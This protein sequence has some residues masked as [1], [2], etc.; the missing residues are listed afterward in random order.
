[1][2]LL[3]LEIVCKS[4]L[5]KLLASQNSDKTPLDITLD[6]F[7]SKLDAISDTLHKDVQ[8][9]KY[10][11]HSDNNFSHQ[12]IQNTSTYSQVLDY[13]EDFSPIRKK[14]IDDWFNTGNSKVKSHPMLLIIALLPKVNEIELYEKLIPSSDSLLGHI[15]THIFG[16]NKHV[17]LS[18]YDTDREIFTGNVAGD[19]NYI[20]NFSTLKL[21][22]I[23]K[24]RNELGFS[25][26]PNSL[27]SKKLDEIM[28][29]LESTNN[30]KEN[31]VLV[32][33]EDCNGTG[34]VKK[35][36]GFF[37]AE[38]KCP[39]CNGYGDLIDVKDTS[40]NTSKENDIKSNYNKSNADSKHSKDD[41]EYPKW[42]KGVITAKGNSIHVNDIN[43]KMK[44]TKLLW[45]TFDEVFVKALQKKVTEGTWYRLWFLP[46]Y[47]E[48]YTL[49]DFYKQYEEGQM[50]YEKIPPVTDI[51]SLL[52]LSYLFSNEE[53]ILFIP[54]N[55]PTL[56]FIDF[57]RYIGM[58]EINDGYTEDHLKRIEELKKFYP[59][60]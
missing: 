33:C 47:F 30:S 29:F 9:E 16:D 17:L 59:N 58:I 27:L 12:L 48:V 42:D 41:F 5:A 43:E 11:V 40:T 34:K 10:F 31:E 1:M 46:A 45:K 4:D 39:T 22:N 35:Q 21:E 18:Q 13:T 25:N 20:L 7:K 44:K 49:D 15:S 50:E 37:S 52:D 38:V 60:N 51:R 28:P 56:T 14:L 19:T 57:V 36:Q 53:L 6:Y 2:E 55:H 54:K 32:K 3:V 8:N 26:K 24:L 23:T